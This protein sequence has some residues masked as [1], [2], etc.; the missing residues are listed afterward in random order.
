MKALLIVD[1]QNDF[2][3]HGSLAVTDGEAII[4]SINALQ[5]MFDYVVAS[6][7]WHPATHKSFAKNHTSQKEFDVINWRGKEQV[8]W[9]MHCVQ[10]SY[11]A[12]LSDRLHSAAIAAIIRK[13]MREEVDSYSAF[14]DNDHSSSTGLLGWLQEMAITELYVCGLAADFCVFYT[15]KDAVQNGLTTFYIEDATRAISASGYEKAK[16]ELLAL[17]VEF[18]TVETLKKKWDFNRTS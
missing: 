7:D 17:G 11:G 15:A 1:V 8:L 14:F 12:Q 16:K 3:S 4:D 2:L 10:N 9:P 5:P 18:C 6:Q 13:G